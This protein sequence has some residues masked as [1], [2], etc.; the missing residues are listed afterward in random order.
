MLKS[1]F[2]A[3]TNI[4]SW[5]PPCSCLLPYTKGNTSH[6]NEFR[7]YSYLD[8]DWL[9]LLDDRWST[10]GYCTFTG[11]NTVPYLDGVRPLQVRWNSI[12]MEVPWVGVGGIIENEDGLILLSYS[13]PVWFCSVNKAELS[14][15]SHA[16]THAYISSHE[17]LRIKQLWQGPVPK[18]NIN[19][20]SVL[21]VS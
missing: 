5:V 19:L 3:N 2:P 13:D 6:S 9:G 11:D 8:V 18:V 14:P 4:S 15:F 7:I 17:R 21:L 1:V 16:R 20:W 10:S 12:F